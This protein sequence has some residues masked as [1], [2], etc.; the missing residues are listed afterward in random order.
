MHFVLSI[1]RSD[2]ESGHLAAKRRRIGFQGTGVK[3]GRVVLGRCDAGC[4][5]L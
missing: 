2:L 5:G 4:E 3:E 1:V